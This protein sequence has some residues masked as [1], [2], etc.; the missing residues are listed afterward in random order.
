MKARQDQ[1]KQYA[2]HLQSQY[3]DRL[4]YWQSRGSS[5]L[6]TPYEAT[7][8]VDGIDQAKFAYPRSP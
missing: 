6:R 3:N 2:A 5:R 4:Q 7:I 8:I 1:M